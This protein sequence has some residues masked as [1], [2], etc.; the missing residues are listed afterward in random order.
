MERSDYVRGDV[1][2]LMI[3]LGVV[4]DSLNA[5]GVDKQ[6]MAELF[7]DMAKKIPEVED[8]SSDSLRNTLLKF[9]G[10]MAGDK[11]LDTLFH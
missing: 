10:L 4:F 8:E 1:G 6:A 2:A 3:V 7:L 9:H 11:P 5:L